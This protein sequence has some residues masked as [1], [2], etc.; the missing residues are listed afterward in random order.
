VDIG[1]ARDRD[2]AAASPDL[3]LHET[4]PHRERLAE[5]SISG[6]SADVSK[7][8]A[9]ITNS[10]APAGLAEDSGDSTPPNQPM[11]V[12]VSSISQRKY[13]QRVL[14]CVGHL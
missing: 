3:N 12:R 11:K 14:Q 4:E 1:L 13:H 6:C 7:R 5:A 10:P 9:A 2:T 8:G